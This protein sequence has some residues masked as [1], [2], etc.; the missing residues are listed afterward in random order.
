MTVSMTRWYRLQT[1]RAGELR[2]VLRAI[3]APGS[4][5][6]ISHHLPDGALRRDRDASDDD[7]RLVCDPVRDHLEVFGDVYLTLQGRDDKLQMRI[8][9][10]TLERVR[11]VLERL[12]RELRLE[13]APSPRAEPA[14]AVPAKRR[15]RCFLTYR[16]DQD[17]TS[18]ALKVQRF[19]G[20]L[21][22]E[23][24]TASARE[25]RSIG[26]KV[27]AKVDRERDFIAVVVSSSGECPWTPDEI[28]RA[29]AHG[30]VIVPVVEDGSRFADGLFGNLQPASFAPG[31]VGD[32]FLPL[33]EAVRFVT[34]RAILD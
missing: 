27:L 2:R 3:L 6:D 18:I 22:V 10:D 20:L 5:V 7:L 26:E 9:A 24:V 12:E 34:S 19:L 14:S 1:F 21:D 4:T 23:V 30:A 25:P 11:A 15:I 33:L 28:G 29:S 32:A 13:E 17:T 31:H 16:F 8:S